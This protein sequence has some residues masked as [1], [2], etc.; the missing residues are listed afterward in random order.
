MGV[1]TRQRIGQTPLLEQPPV[2]FQDALVLQKETKTSNP[3]G[4]SF[5]EDY[6]QSI[7]CR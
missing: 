2:D 4:R 6:A 1:Q 7:E 3:P 5:D